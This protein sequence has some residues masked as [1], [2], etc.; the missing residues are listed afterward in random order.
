[1]VASVPLAERIEAVLRQI[2]G[3]VAVR[4]VATDSAVTEIHVLAQ[5]ARPA[6]QVVRDIES[7]CAA[8]F[9]LDIDHRC[10]SVAQIEVP[11]GR[12][13]LQRPRLFSVRVEAIGEEVTAAVQ[14]IV[15]DDI[16]SGEARGPAAGAFRPRLTAKATVLALESL[17]DGACR[18]DLEDLREFRMA[19][20]QGYVCAVSLLSHSGEEK[21][22][23]CALVRTDVPEACARA[24]LDAVN[25][26]LERL[27][28]TGHEVVKSL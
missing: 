21:L 11:T 4:V 17:L 12:K 6:K 19:Q 5:L 13:I 28:H 3:V 7:V 27:H 10:V 14:L 2:R 25:R 9:H 20:H 16:I 22:I 15:G 18:L 1:M 26:R 8:R 23:G 24:V